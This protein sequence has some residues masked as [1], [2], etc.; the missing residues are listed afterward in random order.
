MKAPKTVPAMILPGK[1]ITSADVQLLTAT[2]WIDEELCKR[3]LLRRV[4][5]TEGAE[6]LGYDAS[7]AEDYSGIVFPVFNLGETRAKTFTLRRDH[8]TYERNK[9]GDLVPKKKYLNPTGAGNPV[10]A[11]PGTPVEVLS[12]STEDR[13]RVLK[14]F[15]YRQIPSLQEYILVDS[16]KCKVTSYKKQEDG[17]WLDAVT[18]GI[19]ATL[20]I[21]TISMEMTMSDIYTRTDFTEGA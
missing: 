20:L 4:D 6:L 10:Y 3:A 7:S 17:S 2:S 16:N 18:E 5:R 11:V 15:F 19:N 9:K 8:P 1:P 14:F 12:D 21:D 13:D